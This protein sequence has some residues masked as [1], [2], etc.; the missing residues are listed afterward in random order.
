MAN[1]PT[2]FAR[3]PRGQSKKETPRKDL[4]RIDATFLE[5]FERA[6]LNQDLSTIMTKTDSKMSIEINAQSNIGYSL[7]NKQG[8]TVADKADIKRIQT[9]SASITKERKAALGEEIGAMTKFTLAAFVQKSNELAD[10]QAIQRFNKG[11]VGVYRTVNTQ[12]QTITKNLNAIESLTT[13]AGG[14]DEV[15]NIIIEMGRRISIAVGKYL[16]HRANLAEDATAEKLNKFL[17]SEHVPIW[18]FTKLSAALI[19]TTAQGF[20]IRHVLFPKDPSKGVFLTFKEIRS[21]EFR[22]DLMGLLAG[23]Q[24]LIKLAT[25]DVLIRLMINLPET[26][27]LDN[28]DEAN[29]VAAKM[30]NTPFF[31]V[32]FEGAVETSEVF[33]FLAKN[34]VRGVTWASGTVLTPPDLL[35]FYGTISKRMFY[36]LVVRPQTKATLL[37]D[38]FPGFA[39]DPASDTKDIFVQL[40]AW[41]I[42][43]G[44]DPLW[45]A[46]MRGWATND[47]SN[48]TKRK[49]FNDV[50]MVATDH[51]IATAH[52]GLFN[53]EAIALHS[54]TVTGGPLL[55]TEVKNMALSMRERR[56]DADII[57]GDR[58]SFSLMKKAKVPANNRAGIQERSRLSEDARIALA[59]LRSRGYSALAIRMQVWFR[60]FLDEN[61]QNAVATVFL[62]RLESFLDT[63]LETTR[64]ERQAIM[65]PADPDDELVAQEVVEVIEDDPNEA[66]NPDEE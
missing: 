4:I 31:V 34:G 35:K 48:V 41:S 22:N 65:D 62:A 28:F 44:N 7:V 16:I 37:G 60:L 1:K 6:N 32:P 55:F 3:V 49:V 36:A 57:I 39:Y 56:V 20:D 13:Q 15:K 29:S 64:E 45:F 46:R 58:I 23:S 59:E 12:Y 18:L 21:V 8:N 47:P 9:M 50:V 27:G 52:R 17:F 26:T 30:A 54:G 33:N 42:V 61:V 24:H 40:K 5:R 51:A 66:H 38:M 63:P 43:P 19:S 14:T 53:E 11:F 25:N 2:A 10:L